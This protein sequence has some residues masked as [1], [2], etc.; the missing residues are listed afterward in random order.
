VDLPV[1]VNDL[2]AHF[3]QEKGTAEKFLAEHL[4]GLEEFAGKVADDLTQ[5]AIGLAVPASTRAMLAA[6]L[7]SVEAEVAQVEAD[8]K[9]AAE[10]KAAADA[11]A[12]VAEPAPVPDPA[13]A[14]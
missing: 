9:A 6:F 4:P 13:A 8:T 12:A 14:V 10:A 1:M 5:V 11:A 7:K 3:E 2:K